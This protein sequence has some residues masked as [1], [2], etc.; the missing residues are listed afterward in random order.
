MK[1]TIVKCSKPSFWYSESIGQSFHV[2]MYT[3]THYKVRN[4]SELLINKCDCSNYFQNLMEKA[5]D[6]TR[7]NK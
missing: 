7:N 2:E 4:N 1:V 6:K 5:I 3:K